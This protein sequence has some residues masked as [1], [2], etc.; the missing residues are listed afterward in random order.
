MVLSLRSRAADDDPA[1]RQR[2]AAIGAHFDRHLIGGAADAARTHFNRRRDILERLTEHRQRIGLDLALDA[3]EGAID[4]RLGDRLLAFVHDR[5]HEF[6]DD[7]IAELGVRD[8][9]AFLSAVTARHG[10]LL[11]LLKRI[12]SAAWRRISNGAA[13]G[14]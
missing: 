2:L 12:T 5:V 3:L 9:L 8:D 10:L 6:R 13:C 4:D 11:I 7:E 14:P 1:D